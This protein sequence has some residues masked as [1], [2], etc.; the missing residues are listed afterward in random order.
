MSNKIVR[1]GAG[2]ISRSSRIHPRDAI[3]NKSWNIVK[4]DTV[5]IISGDDKGKEGRVKKVLRFRN[6]V[7]VE[8]VNLIKKRVRGS[9][10]FKGGIYSLEAPVHYSSVNL[11]DPETKKATPV[12]H[13]YLEDGTKVRV[14]KS[15]AVIP[16]PPPKKRRKERKGENAAG[17]G[18]TDNHSRRKRHIRRFSTQADVRD[19]HCPNTELD[20]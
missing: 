10:E 14:A 1:A 16:K 13:K 17:N 19:S 6:A 7:I 11:I 3:P 9:P 12:Q 2:Y 15:G 5:K 4:G 20:R 18:E 8:G